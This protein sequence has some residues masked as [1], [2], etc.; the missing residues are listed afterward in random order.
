[1]DK[2][3]NQLKALQNNAIVP[4]SHYRVAC[5][6]KTDCGEF[7]GVNIEPDVLNLGIC[8]ERNAVF[9]A[10]TNGAKYLEHIYLLTDSNHDF[11]TPCGACRQ[12]LIQFSDENTLITFFNLSGESKTTKLFELLPMMW[13][14]KDLVN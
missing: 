9:S 5:L 7:V 12:V 2:I 11:G 10:L 4:F 1:M 3:F 13:S 14:K 6:L 8:G